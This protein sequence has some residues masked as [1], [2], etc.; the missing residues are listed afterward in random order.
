MITDNWTFL[1]NLEGQE[2]VRSNLVYTPYVSPD[3][4][5]LCMSFNR[6]VNYHRWPEENKLWT[7]EL[8]TDRFSREVTFHEIA[9]K[10]SIPTLKIQ[11][12]N[13]FKREIYIDWHGDDFLMQGINNGGYDKVL[14]NWQAQWLDRITEMKKA[15][16]YKFSLHPN[17]W[18]AIDGVLTPYNWFFS[19]NKTDP[20]IKIRDLLI[21]ISI[22]RQDKLQLML[23]HYKMDLD[24]PYDIPTLQLI[25]FNSFR[26]NYPESLIDQAIKIN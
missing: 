11:D 9:R 22:D 25:C 7:N 19:F 15:G 26:S 1:Y 6:D 4:K 21:Q 18:V 17:S 23:D 12:I 2:W 3:K 5:T 14:P 13:V 24:T 10:A 20:K 8:L 16:I